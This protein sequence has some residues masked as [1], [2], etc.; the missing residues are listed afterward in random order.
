MNL[1]GGTSCHRIVSTGCKDKISQVLNLGMH[2]RFFEF[3]YFL[4]APAYSVL[5]TW[6]AIGVP[7]ACA[8]KVDARTHTSWQIALIK[9]ARND[10]W[11]L[12]RTC[13]IPT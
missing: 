9:I 11:C 5:G 1:N 7:H 8:V 4:N 3:V 6:V 2:V 12:A 13:M 10:T